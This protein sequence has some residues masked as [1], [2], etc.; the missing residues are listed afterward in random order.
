L[1]VVEIHV[2]HLK[3]IAWDLWASYLHPSVQF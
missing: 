2:L 1:F 3:Y